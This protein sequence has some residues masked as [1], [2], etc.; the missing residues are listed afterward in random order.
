MKNITPMKRLQQQFKTIETFVSSFFEKVSLNQS[1]PKSYRVNYYSFKETKGVDS[2]HVFI[3]ESLKNSRHRIVEENFAFAFNGVQEN[4]DLTTVTC[5]VKSIEGVISS[6]VFRFE[7]FKPLL[8]D[9]IKQLELLKK[10]DQ[11]NEK[12]IIISFKESF[13]IGKDKNDDID[14][15]IDHRVK[16]FDKLSQSEFKEL[17]KLQKELEEAQKEMIESKES[18]D[19]FVLEVEYNLGIPELKKKISE[20]TKNLDELKRKSNSM[21]KNSAKQNR[22]NKSI[23]SKGLVAQKLR[24]VTNNIQLIKSRISR[25]LPKIL[26]KRF[27]E[28]IENKIK[29]D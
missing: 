16:E 23:N 4:T 21:I 25:T 7:K 18:L 15:E 28:I 19:S 17:E 6:Q 27:E 1:S 24:K 11:L 12:N 8:N 9:W 13:S 14:A 5:S 22:Y 10:I 3:Y 26:S 2:E 29:K 20:L